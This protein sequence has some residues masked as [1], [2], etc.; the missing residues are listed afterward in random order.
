MYPNTNR[1][2]RVNL[3][4][5]DLAAIAWIFAKRDIRS[6]RAVS[7]DRPQKFG[8]TQDESS[9]QVG[10]GIHLGDVSFVHLRRSRLRTGTGQYRFHSTD[11]KR[12]SMPYTQAT[13]STSACDYHDSPEFSRLALD[14]T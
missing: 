1:K 6:R 14:G 7:G 3:H 12:I 4:L 5:V 2:Q 11:P 9:E 13:L 10:S 8:Y